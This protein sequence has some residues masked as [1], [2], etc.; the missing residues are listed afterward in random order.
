[1]DLAV[2]GRWSRFTYPLI[3]GIPLIGSHRIIIAANVNASIIST[4]NYTQTHYQLF[5]HDFNNKWK[6]NTALF[7]IRGKGYFQRI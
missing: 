7:F 5:D 2:D 3:N 1:M 6:F 4:D